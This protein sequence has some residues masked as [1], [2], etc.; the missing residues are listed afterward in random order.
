M[1]IRLFVMTPRYAAGKG[2]DIFLF[3]SFL[4]FVAE[5]SPAYSNFLKNCRLL[6][7]FT[8]AGKFTGVIFSDIA[9]ASSSAQAPSA[10]FN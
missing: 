6:G 1:L 7:K 3:P 8:G 5:I 4:P 2:S 10:P 9:A